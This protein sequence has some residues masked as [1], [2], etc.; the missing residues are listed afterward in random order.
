MDTIIQEIR[1]ASL[2]DQ[3]VSLVAQRWAKSF[4]CKVTINPGSETDEPDV[5]GWQFTPSGNQVEWIAEVETEDSLTKLDR[6]KRWQTL[7]DKSVPFYLVVP[8][9]YRSKVRQLAVMA[10]VDLN[11]IYEYAFLNETFQLA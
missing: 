3:V 6:Y 5:L 11:G 9:G 2:H 1:I 4:Q 8:K 7:A 10:G